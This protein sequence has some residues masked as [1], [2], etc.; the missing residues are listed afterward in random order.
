MNPAEGVHGRYPLMMCACLCVCVSGVLWG[1]GEGGG[2]VKA[3]GGRLVL[4][5]ESR[6]SVTVPAE[7]E[8]KGSGCVCEL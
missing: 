3:M 7:C 8:G 4:V 2:C 1:Q 5:C 6:E